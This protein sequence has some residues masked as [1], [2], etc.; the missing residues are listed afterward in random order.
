MFHIWTLRIGWWEGGRGWKGGGRGFFITL[1]PL[2][3]DFF[4]FK[5]NFIFLAPLFPPS[6]SSPSTQFIK[7]FRNKLPK[8]RRISRGKYKSW[9]NGEG[10]GGGWVGR[11]GRM[12]G[13]RMERRRRGRGRGSGDVIKGV[14]RVESVGF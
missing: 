10:G 2:C 14:Q 7:N 12:G 1:F 4:I 6:L 5:F 3:L 9:A 11:R 13:K 8:I